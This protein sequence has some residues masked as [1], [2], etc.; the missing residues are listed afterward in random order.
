MDQPK[1]K[2]FEELVASI[3]RQI[4]GD[5]TVKLNDQILGKRAV[6]LARLT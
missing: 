5:A 2:Q 6:S 3:Q 1:W 4:A